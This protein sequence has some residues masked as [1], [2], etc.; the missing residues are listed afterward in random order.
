MSTPGPGTDVVAWLRGLGLGEYAAAFRENDVGAEVLAKLTAEDLKELGVRSV[1]HRRM[2]LDAIAALQAVA[3]R[4]PPAAT[5]D[6]PAPTAP[7][8]EAKGA[9]RRQL[10]VLFCD[11]AGSTALSARLDPED[12]RDVLAAYHRVVTEAVQGQGGYVAK[13]LGDGVLAYFGWPRA[14][15]DDAERAVRGGLAAVEAVARLRTPRGE[16][17]AARVGIATGPVVVGEVLGEGTEAR[18]C[19]VVGETPNLAARR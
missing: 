4:P 6:V 10:T 3:A 2:L 11:L 8:A 1:G 15:E 16:P 9:E 17:L 18:E 13:Y 7:S 14:H 5:A 19:G 12:M